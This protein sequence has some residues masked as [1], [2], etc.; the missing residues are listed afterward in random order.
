MNYNEILNQIVI[1]LHNKFPGTELETGVTDYKQ[2][3]CVR[4]RY[5]ALLIITTWNSRL[6]LK[7]VESENNNKPM[8][9]SDPN[10]MNE[11]MSKVQRTINN[12]D[13]GNRSNF[14]FKDFLNN[15]FI[16]E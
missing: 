10:F 9:L 8:S 12:I 11:L 16:Y 5:K 15:E 1:E 7:I 13:A 14:C 6:T 2:L 3:N 4:L